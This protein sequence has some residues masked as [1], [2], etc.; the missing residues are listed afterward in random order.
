MDDDDNQNINDDS[1]N[2]GGSEITIGS[3]TEIHGFQNRNCNEKYYG[4]RGRKRRSNNSKK[5]TRHRRDVDDSES[6]EDND[7]DLE[8]M[9]RPLKR[10]R[11]SSENEIIRTSRY[12][13]R[14]L[15]RA[16]SVS[17][18]KKYYFFENERGIRASRDIPEPEQLINCICG[19][20]AV[21]TR[22]IDAY[23]GDGPISCN[24][25]NKE[26]WNR[27][28]G[29]IM[30]YHCPYNKQKINKHRSGYDLCVKCAENA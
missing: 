12:P 4:K 10:R 11:E 30:I 7:T 14:N 6:S 8:I 29:N 20:S 15:N 27:R 23:D 5:R 21:K 28:D 13:K 22:L 9:S 17:R 26:F 24:K 16:S 2:N 25:C 19:S 1:D 18:K 3:E